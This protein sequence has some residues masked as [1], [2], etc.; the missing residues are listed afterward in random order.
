MKSIKIFIASSDELA[1]D[2]NA[3]GNLVRRLD[4]IYEKRGIRIELFEWEDYDA[5]YNNKRKQ[6]EYNDQIKA[7]DMFLALFHTKAGRFTIEEFD[8]ATEEFRLHASPKVYAYCKDLQAGDVESRELKEFK[9]RLFE[10]LGHYWCRYN[11]RDSMQLHFV[12]QLQLVETN[13]SEA[14]TVEDGIVKFGE[15]PIA[16]FDN[17]SFA[18]GNTSYKNM[19]KELN[20]LPEKIEKA[21]LRLEKMPNDEDLQDD[22]Q[23][24]KNRF[25]YLKEVFNR[26]Q[27][28]LLDT[29][30]RIAF[31]Q[32]EKV[33][34]AIRR[35]IDAFEDGNLERANI[36]L[37]EVA[38]EADQHMEQLS[39][40][41]QLVHQDIEALHLQT[42]TLMADITIPIKER[43]NRIAAIC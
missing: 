21:R 22:L 5:A 9:R 24:K 6:D 41:R 37:E 11:N 43:I 16:Q 12:M 13:E 8:L 35:A 40:Q 17:L 19:Q 32:Q 10:E 28:A 20:E 29:A 39:T 3:F 14:L 23:Q 34:D 7:S 38:C 30:K 33:S 36:L 42:K 26:Q 25:V 31:M 2:R 18:A 4:A 1:D 15:T 27:Q